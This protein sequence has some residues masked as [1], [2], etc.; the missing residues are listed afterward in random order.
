[1]I[2]VC[3][4]DSLK[5]APF[6][7]DVLQRYRVPKEAAHVLV[8]HDG[9]DTIL[10]CDQ[11]KGNPGL[12][13]YDFE[14]FDELSVALINLFRILAKQQK[15]RDHQIMV[16][17]TGGQ[18]VTSVVAAAVTFNR[19]IQTQYVQTGGNHE[20]LGYDVILD[21]PGEPLK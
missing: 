14:R 7:A 2:L 16:D 6:F 8:R 21:L 17:F 20:V 4:Q 3:S 5:E 13:G 9:K 12:H 11:A 15:A 1:V 18:K 19:E 10:P